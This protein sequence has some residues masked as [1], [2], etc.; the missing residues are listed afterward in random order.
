MSCFQLSERFNI[1]VLKSQLSFLTRSNWSNLVVTVK[2]GEFELIIVEWLVLLLRNYPNVNLTLDYQCPSIYYFLSIILTVKKTYFIKMRAL[3]RITFKK[4]NASVIIQVCV[5][6]NHCWWTE[7]ADWDRWWEA[8]FVIKVVLIFLF[9]SIFW[10]KVPIFPILWS[11]VSDFPKRLCCWTPCT[12]KVTKFKI[13]LIYCI[14]R[15]TRIFYIDI[16]GYHLHTGIII[17]W[18]WVRSKRL[19]CFLV[20]LCKNSK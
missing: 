15:S 8:I 17:W 11:W 6:L 1:K 19:N 4:Q 5:H 14:P 7:A 16:R 12:W 2:V 13:S 9:C 18:R 10:K 3:R 20:Q